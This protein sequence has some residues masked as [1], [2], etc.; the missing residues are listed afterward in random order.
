MPDFAKPLPIETWLADVRKYFVDTAPEL[1][2]LYDTY[3][4][5]AAHGRRYIASD[6]EH[7]DPGARLLEVGAGSL[8]LSCQLV[9][10]GFRVTALEPIGAGFSH[11]EQ[12]RKIIQERSIAWSCYPR[13]LNMAAEDFA[14][15][16]SYDYAFSV[17]VMEHV[18]NIERVLANV[19]NSLIAGACYRFTCPNYLFPYEPHFNIPTFFSKQLTEKMFGHRIHSADM[20]D[21]SGTW[22][23]LNWINVKQLQAIAKRLPEL[24]MSFNRAIL[25]STLER[26]A[27][28]H[29][30][31]GRRSPTVRKFLSLLVRLRLHHFFRAVPAMLQPLMDCRL[32]KIS[33]S[34]IGS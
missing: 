27:V 13:V 18:E 26:L 15:R 12:M 8:L 23:S 6:L 19:G 2:S 34:R 22:G 29:H 28:D 5:E 4:K 9:R 24:Q 14:E 31:A 7:L 20:P 10:E 3:A 21:P 33:D 1:V 32:K 17:N 25:V 11:V 16:N 30:F